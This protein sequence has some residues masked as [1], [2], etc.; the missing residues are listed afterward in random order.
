MTA[1][2]VMKEVLEGGAELVIHVGDIA[3]SLFAFAPLSAM[4]TAG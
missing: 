2:Q 3:V 1:E 4:C